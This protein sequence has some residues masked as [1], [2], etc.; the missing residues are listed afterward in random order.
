MM[1]QT[2]VQMITQAL[3]G[4]PVGS[5][6]H[7]AAINAMRQLS[8]HVPQG[9]PTTGVQQTQLQDMLRSLARNAL[10]Q[11]IMQQRSQ[12]GGGG[13]QPGAQAPPPTTPLPGA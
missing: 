1:L 11:R 10:L 6:A 9:A 13:Q 3:Q 12:Q 4:L 7:T 5:E 8:R 2:A